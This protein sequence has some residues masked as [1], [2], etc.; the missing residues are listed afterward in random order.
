MNRWMKEHNRVEFQLARKNVT[1][2]ISVLAKYLISPSHEPRLDDYFFTCSALKHKY[3]AT[4]SNESRKDD[5][6]HICISI[7]NADHGF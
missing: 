7:T 6:I 1:E 3:L 4:H 2:N 5:F